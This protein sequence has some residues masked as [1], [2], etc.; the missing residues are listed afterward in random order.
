MFVY[1]P[2]SGLD[3]MDTNYEFNFQ[4]DP[5]ALKIV[6]DPRI[7]LTQKIYFV[8]WENVSNM[9]ISLVS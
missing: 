4:Q 5:D 6:F 2:I 1:A 9:K 3:A 8:S 7:Q